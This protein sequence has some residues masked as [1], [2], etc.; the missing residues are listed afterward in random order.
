MDYA[1]LCTSNDRHGEADFAGTVPRTCGAISVFIGTTR[2]HFEGKTVLKLS[3]EAYGA[4]GRARAGQK[5][6]RTSARKW[7]RQ[8]NVAVVR[9]AGRGAGGGGRASLSSSR[10]RTGEESQAAVK[11]IIDQVK[12]RLP[13][14]KKEIY[15]DGL[16]EWKENTECFWKAP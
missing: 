5:C 12:S 9:S 1:E 6:A 11:W 15:D 14:W 4:H 3:Y 16:S 10:R 13:V 7:K 8:R 2:N